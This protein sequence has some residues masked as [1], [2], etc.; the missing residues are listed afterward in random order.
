MKSFELRM[1]LVMHSLFQEPSASQSFEETA[2]EFYP[3]VRFKNTPKI[4]VNQPPLPPIVTTNPPRED[5]ALL[6]ALATMEKTVISIQTTE[7]RSLIINPTPDEYVLAFIQDVFYPK[8][9][10]LSDK[11][12]HRFCYEYA[13]QFIRQRFNKEYGSTLPRN[14]SR[15][16][17][18]SIAK[19]AEL[20]VSCYSI[21]QCLHSDRGWEGHPLQSLY[22]LI[23]EICLITPTIPWFKQEKKGFDSLVREQQRI[24]AE[25]QNCENPFPVDRPE[26]K[27]FVDCAIALANESSEG[28]NQWQRLVKARKSLTATMQEK[29]GTVWDFS[30]NP[31]VRV[32]P[33]RTKKSK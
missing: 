1:A 23:F 29:G 11:V 12:V 18:E 25:L 3:T 20:W 14:T 15:I 31:P 16:F 17:K 4:V 27:F 13:V 26:T 2:A 33:G 6:S 30:H 28:W 8:T 10:D 24:N 32:A 22:S 19:T 9:E 5:V 21:L 7:F